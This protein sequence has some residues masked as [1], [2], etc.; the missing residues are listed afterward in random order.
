MN[1]RRECIDIK[2]MRFTPTDRC[3]ATSFQKSDLINKLHDPKPSGLRRGAARATS[4]LPDRSLTSSSFN[5]RG[6][7]A[8]SNEAQSSELNA[9]SACHVLASAIQDIESILA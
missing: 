9:L 5:L 1:R 2:A 3:P 8:I 6:T 4:P 7:F